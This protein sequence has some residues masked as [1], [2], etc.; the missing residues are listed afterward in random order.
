MPTLHLLRQVLQRTACS[1]AFVGA[2]VASILAWWVLEALLPVGLTSEGSHRL[3]SHYQIAFLVGAFVAAS[4]A[5]RLARFAALLRPMGPLRRVLA[6]TL[7]MG[8]SGA[9]AAG[10]LLLVAHGT[11][12]W[13]L[14]DF[15][16]ARSLPALG[17]ALAHLCAMLALALRRPAGDRG[18]L[19]PVAAVLALTLLLPGLLTGTHPVSKLA[20]SALDVTAPLRASFDFRE[21]HAPWGQGGA[22]MMGLLQIL[23]W[24][25]CAAALAA[26]PGPRR[27]GPNPHALRDP[28]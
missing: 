23:G 14:E 13:Q 8:G 16:T 18:A 7:C 28:R 24:S 11:R 20:L 21:G 5:V 1:G 25:L 12:T 4:T 15:E 2:V 19:G 26:S 3:A 6:E 22:W 10:P 27:V 9:L 17:V